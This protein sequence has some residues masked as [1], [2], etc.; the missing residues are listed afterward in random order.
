MTVASAANKVTMNGNGATTS[1]PFSFRI[2][3]S[4]DLEIY[5]TDT[6]GVQTEITSN[7]SV[8][9]NGESGGTVTYPSTGSPLASGETITIIRVT[10][11]AQSVDFTSQGAFLPQ[12]HE[13]ADDRA[14]MILQELDEKIDRAFKLPTSDTSGTATELTTD[15][16]G[17]AGGVLYIQAGVLKLSE[18]ANIDNLETLAGISGDITTVAANDANITTVA[19]D[20]NGADT[21]GTVAGSIAN[22]NSV[23][24]NISNVIAVDG[25]AANINAAVAN[26]TNINTVAGISADVTTVAGISADVTTVA[27]DTADI[28]TVAA[29]LNGPDTIGA[30]VASAA[31]AAASASAAATSESNAATSEANA[32]ASAT[33]AAFSA[34]SAAAAAN[35][36]GLVDNIAALKALAGGVNSVVFVR[37]HTT[38][39]D[40]GDD[41]F[42]WESSNTDTDDNGITIQPNAGGT[43]RW[44]RR[45]GRAIIPESFGVISDDNSEAANNSSK[46]QA[47]FDATTAGHKGEIPAGK[48]YYYDT[49]LNLSSNTHV[50]FYGDLQYTGATI[51]VDGSGANDVILRMHGGSIQGNARKTVSGITAANPGVVTA[52][53]HGFSNGDEVVLWDVE[54]MTELNGQKWT[55]ANVTANTFEIGD[56]SSYTAYESGGVALGYVSSHRGIFCQSPSLKSVTG[57][58]Q[59][60]PVVLTV[61][62]HGFSNGDE[63]YVSDLGGMTEVNNRWFTVANVTT[64]TLELSGEDGT[65]H[66]AYTSGGFASKIVYAEDWDISGARVEGFAG[67]GIRMDWTKRLRHG[68]IVVKYC[69][70]GGLVLLSAVDFIADRRIEC[71]K[72]GPGTGNTAYPVS[73]TRNYN[74]PDMDL[75]AAPASSGTRTGLYCYDNPYYVAYDTHGGQHIDNGPIRWKNCRHGINFEHATSDTAVVAPQYVT[76]SSHE[77]EGPDPTY[78]SIGPAFVLDGRSAGD[79]EEQIG[80]HVGD[81]S[82]RWHGHKTLGSNTFSDG[83]VF[84][85]RNSTGFRTGTVRCVDCYKAGVYTKAKVYGLDTQGL[86]VIDLIADGGVQAAVNVTDSDCSLTVDGVLMDGSAGELLRLDDSGGFGVE[87]GPNFGLGNIVRSGASMMTANSKSYLRRGAYVMLPRARM[88]LDGTAGV[89]A[90][91]VTGATQANPVVITTSVSH[92]FSNGDEIRLESLGGMTELNGRAFTIANVT[93]TTFELSGEDGTGHTAYT[94]GGTAYYCLEPVWETTATF[95][96]SY[97]HISYRATGQYRIHVTSGILSNLRAFTYGGT[98]LN[99]SSVTVDSINNALIQVR[100][101]DSS[102]TPTDDSEIWVEFGGV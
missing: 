8:V 51:A 79:T 62:A 48:D 85:L 9:V 80:L 92:G 15:V 65:G 23:G 27:A 73:D 1:W 53:A 3:D 87:K 75:T 102:N 37:G 41:P 66:T 29:D 5:K 2:F 98:E 69:G 91:S 96:V 59:A 13:D 16:A 64:N 57:A 100:V 25:N 54:G 32:S 12:N 97:D 28:G 34:A 93:A 61:A 70:Y 101:N 58:T 63:I 77:G 76:F 43:G 46:L 36:I 44:V 19:T 84:Y 31:A 88:M 33:A 40:G 6:S 42:D 21:I 67:T 89:S 74:S 11:R 60:N 47:F 20:L 24:G 50:E 18:A 83:G 4:S 86:S 30:A 22:V 52:T 39:G 81:G 68:G 82:V 7:F 95:E 72:M 49:T 35:E 94:S 55:I 14:M 10:V 26:A 45:Y 99:A 56:T 90:K 38:A 17:S 71:G 78:F